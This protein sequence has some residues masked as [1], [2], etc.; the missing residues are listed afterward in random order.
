[1]RVHVDGDLRGRVQ[2]AKR[3][4]NNVDSGAQNKFERFVA[5]SS[6]FVK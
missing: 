5:I 1:M 6:D 4:A 3:R 2:L